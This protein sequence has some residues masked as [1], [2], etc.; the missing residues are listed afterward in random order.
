MQPIC[1]R[2]LLT[3]TRRWNVRRTPLL[4]PPP[5]GQRCSVL[6]LE[7]VGWEF[8]N[9]AQRAYQELIYFSERW[10]N[11]PR[12][13]RPARVKRNS[14]KFDGRKGALN[15]TRYKKK[16]SSAL[17]TLWQPDNGR[18]N[19][20]SC[21]T[22]HAMRAI[23]L[24]RSFK[25]KRGSFLQKSL[26]C[27]SFIGSIKPFRHCRSKAPS[28]RTPP[29][30]A[31]RLAIYIYIFLAALLMSFFLTTNFHA[32][33]KHNNSIDVMYKS[34]NWGVAGV[35]QRVFRWIFVP[36]NH[37]HGWKYGE[38]N[39]EGRGGGGVMYLPPYR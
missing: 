33:N 9:R 15:L 5:G 18:C 2:K 26:L 31:L 17:P 23:L 38:R 10:K 29:A 11:T 30:R 24:T 21:K 20:W 36:Q 28:T 4:W 8:K 19:T 25:C 27:S 35:L 6:T 14:T 34:Y 13:K 32:S 7:S 3:L 16:L 1:S 12:R 37:R 39:K 22:T